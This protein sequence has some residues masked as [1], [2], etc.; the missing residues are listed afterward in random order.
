VES[1]SKNRKSLKDLNVL[2]LL[3]S[4]KLKEQELKLKNKKRWKVLLII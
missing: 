1:V 2:M 4:N 3:V